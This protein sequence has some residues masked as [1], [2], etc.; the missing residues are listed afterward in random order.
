MAVTPSNMLP[1]GT[2]APNFTLFDTITG[3]AKSLSD[4]KGSNGTLIIFMCNHFPYVIHI[5]D[6]IIAIA[7]DYRN[8]GISIIGISA[9]DI[10]TYPQD[11]PDKMTELMQA[12]GN[13]LDAYLYDES[14]NTAKE[15]MAA[16]TPDLYLFD[17]DDYCVYRGRLDGST[18]GSNIPLTG[19]DIR[20]ALDALLAGEPPISDQIPSMGCN[21]KWL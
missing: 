10:V 7:N 19:E 13:P 20:R 9:N 2:K 1:L 11:A 8:K 17:A 16:C 18:P 12:W 21:I 4:L 5:R 6:Q 3:H 15:Y 14:Q